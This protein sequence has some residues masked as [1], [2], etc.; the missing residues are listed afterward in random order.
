MTETKHPQGTT[1]ERS[2]LTTA[3]EAIGTKLGEL[4][5]RMGLA[6]P[7]AKPKKAA[8]PTKKPAASVSKPA[9]PARKSTRRASARGKKAD[10]AAAK[11]RPA[12]A[13]AKRAN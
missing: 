13:R 5:V 11:L 7:A 4:A 6:K 8:R 12:K 3:A 2:T 9:K 1:A 10:A